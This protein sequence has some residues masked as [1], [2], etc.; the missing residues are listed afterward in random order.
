MNTGAGFPVKS[1]EIILLLKI[2]QSYFN[3]A[4]KIQCLKND[5]V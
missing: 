2:E 3:N 4:C 1:T 5:N